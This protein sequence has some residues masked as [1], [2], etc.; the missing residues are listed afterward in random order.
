M[1]LTMPF[2][3]RIL[4]NGYLDELLYEKGILDPSRPFAE[5]KAA[6]LIDDRAKAAGN[7]PAFSRKIREGIP[8][9]KRVDETGEA[10]GYR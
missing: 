9:P 10:P 1:G 2:D 3:W 6:S 5:V 8:I 7:D 4:V